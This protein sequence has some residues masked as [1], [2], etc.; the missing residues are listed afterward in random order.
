MRII[1][2]KARLFGKINVIDFLV[3]SV[4]IF[5]IPMA[6]SGYKLFNKKIEKAGGRFVD[7]KMNFRFIGVPP[8]ISKLITQG[9][10]ETNENGEIIGEITWLSESSPSEYKFDLGQG[11]TFN[12]PNQESQ[13]IPV[14]L[15]IRAMVKNDSL[16]YKD[17]QI[18]MGSPIE[19]RTKKYNVSAIPVK[20]KKEIEKIDLNIILKNLTENKLKLVSVGDKAI[21]R[22]GETVAEI[23]EIGK[24][25]N[26]MH[27]IDLGSGNI[28]AGEESSKKQIFV[29]MRLKC[30]LDQ[31]GKAYFQGK[32][33]TY[34]SLLAFNMDE[35]AVKGKLINLTLTEKW[36]GVKVKFSGIIPELAKVVTEGDVEKD[37]NGRLAGRLKSIIS[38]KPS[39]VNILVIEQNKVITVPQPFQKDIEAIISVL[40]IQ[41]EGTVYFKNYPVKIGNIIT[42]TTDL[43][44]IQGV[45]IG[46]E[47]S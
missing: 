42:F 15:K 24:K 17:K 2:E 39:E 12:Q 11:E 20:E 7:L 1:D 28:I 46:L 18:I 4:F 45:I 16:F 31:D 22:N 34:N 26:D 41:R 27:E 13:E 25:Q 21:G 19:F 29:K 10:R 14:E 44:S 30:E 33:I 6:Y 40:C 23:L 5:I 8:E 47:S 36:L 3:L 35:Y 37:P 43:Y 32:E 38:N 9:D